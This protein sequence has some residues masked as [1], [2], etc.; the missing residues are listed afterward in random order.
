[1]NLIY[2]IADSNKRL[3]QIMYQKQYAKKR[4]LH[5]ITFKDIDQG[6][7]EMSFPINEA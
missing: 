4:S 2:G 5:H 7:R 1:M 6:L 3:A